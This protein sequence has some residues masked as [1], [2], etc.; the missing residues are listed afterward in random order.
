MQRR[1]RGGQGAVQRVVG[2]PQ[3][4]QS[5]QGAHIP[6]NGPVQRIAGQVHIHQGG[7]GTQGHRDGARQVIPRQVQHPQRAAAAQPGRQRAV[8]AGVP[9]VQL[10]QLRQ[11]RQPG[12][13]GPPHW[14][15]RQAQPLERRHASPRGRQGAGQ[16]I[17]L[18]ADPVFAQV[19]HLQAG[20]GAQGCRQRPTQAACAQ[21][22]VPQLLEGGHL[23]GQGACEIVAAQHQ[24][25]QLGHQGQV[26]LGQGAA[27]VVVTQVQGHQLGEVRQMRQVEA[28]ETAHIVEVQRQLHHLAAHAA[29]AMPPVATRLPHPPVAGQPPPGAVAPV[30]EGQQ[31]QPVGAGRHQRVH[32]RAATQPAVP[33]RANAPSP[34]V[35]PRVAPHHRR[36][37]HRV[38]VRPARGGVR[39]HHLTGGVVLERYVRPGRPVRRHSNARR[40]AS[41]HGNSGAHVAGQR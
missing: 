15:A 29:D 13:E 17:A 7:C 27:H 10:L 6:R 30:I 32:A 21:V 37:R 4:A 2:Q 35:H 19:Q 22:Q 38:H 1:Q 9:Q 14:V 28:A 11:R 36:A 5:S 34:V 39:V 23:R 31:T 26:S 8:Q 12:R 40:P 20:H 41:W 33:P 25:L 16:R 18:L 3:G 24:A